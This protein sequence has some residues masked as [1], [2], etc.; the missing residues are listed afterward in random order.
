ISLHTDDS[1]WF[2]LWKNRWKLMCLCLRID[3]S[4]YLQDATSGRAAAYGLSDAARGLGMRLSLQTGMTGI[5]TT[6]LENGTLQSSEVSAQ[7]EQSQE[8]PE[9]PLLNHKP[10]FTFPF[11][12]AGA[13]SITEEEDE[14]QQQ[15][16][17]QPH[18][19][20]RPQKRTRF[21]PQEDLIASVD[22]QNSAIPTQAFALRSTVTLAN[23]YFQPHQITM[24]LSPMRDIKIQKKNCF[25]FL[26]KLIHCK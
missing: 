22:F 18:Q 15:Q 11:A 19:P 10:T 21:H 14:Q 6:I 20:Q 13:A 1:D 2:L 25:L 7:K 5:G 26:T 3:E 4:F 16:P 24:F 12:S 8:E 23:G 9:I 17:P